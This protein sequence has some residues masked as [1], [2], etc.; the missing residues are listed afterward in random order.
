DFMLKMKLNSSLEKDK[1]FYRRLSTTRKRRLLKDRKTTSYQRREKDVVSPFTSQPHF[2]V[3]WTSGTDVF[4]T[5]F[6]W[7]G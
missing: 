6:C 1:T 2:D 3:V 5:T 4:S 7:V